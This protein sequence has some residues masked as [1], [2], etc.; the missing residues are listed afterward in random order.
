[1]YDTYTCTCTI[2]FNTIYWQRMAVLEEITKN[3]NLLF[4]HKNLLNTLL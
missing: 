1:M 2:T 3:K 4:Y